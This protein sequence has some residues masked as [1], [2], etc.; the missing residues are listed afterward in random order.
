M[1][2]EWCGG[3]RKKTAVSV[4]QQKLNKIVLRDFVIK[5]IIENPIVN[6]IIAY[7][8]SLFSHP[9]IYVL[10]NR[11]LNAGW[12]VM[13]LVSLLKHHYLSH[14]K[15]SFSV[16]FTDGNFQVVLFS[17]SGCWWKVDAVLLRI[18]RNW[19]FYYGVGCFMD[20]MSK[21]PSLSGNMP[22]FLHAN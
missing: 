7:S 16:T 6:D 21:F 1:R 3:V 14:Y 4:Y 22:S 5:I 12:E 20:L 10:F 18:G 15:S 13:F 11:T 2:V 9:G 8:I 17:I 19:N